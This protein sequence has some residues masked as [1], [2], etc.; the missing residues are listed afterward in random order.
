MTFNDTAH[1]YNNR[2]A[3]I[4]LRKRVFWLRRGD[5]GGKGDKISFVAFRFHPA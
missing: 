1:L 2:F 5:S 3:I 4:R